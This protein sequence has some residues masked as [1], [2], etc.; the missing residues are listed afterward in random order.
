[1]RIK[2]FEGGQMPLHR[3]LP[4][5]GFNNIFALDYTEVTLKRV[6][7]A[8]ESGR[9]KTDSVVDGAA[10]VAAGVVKNARD[11]IR[12]IA[13]GEIKAAVKFLVAGASAGAKAAVEA[14]GGAV[15]VIVPKAPSGKAGKS[16][17]SA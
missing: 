14:A 10:L 11:G 4:K 15:D 8:I 1:V 17:A 2:G 9:L 16:K 5:R 7:T 3:R 13:T 12:L 6:Q